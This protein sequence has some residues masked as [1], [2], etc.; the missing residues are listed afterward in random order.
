MQD[1]TELRALGD[2]LDAGLPEPSAALRQRVLASFGDAPGAGRPAG[3]RFRITWTARRVAIGGGLAAV[4]AA[5]LLAGSIA[6]WWGPGPGASAAAVRVLD[7]AARLALRGPAL[8]VRP[9]RLVFIESLTASATITGRSGHAPRVTIQPELR[10]IWLSVN[11]TRDG[12]LRE[13]PR[14]GTAPGHPTGPWQYTR[15]PG[16]HGQH[17]AA[18]PHALGSSCDPVPGAPRGLPTTTA[19]MVRYLYRHLDG[20]NPPDQQ[21]FITAGDLIR[22]SYIPPAALAAVF[23][24]AAQIPGVTVA[25]HAVTADGRPGIAVQRIFNG[26]SQQLIF[27]PASYAFIGERQVAVSAASGLRAGTILDSTAV[28]RVAIVDRAGQLP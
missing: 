18:P 19:G 11:G 7:R 2:D 21:A 1:L 15:L 13:Q 20:Q 26:I 4:L 17:P 27:D 25:R 8:A 10:E 5:A 12:L 23:R 22:E 14:S 3:G 28:L 24:A 9:S 16:C 6:G